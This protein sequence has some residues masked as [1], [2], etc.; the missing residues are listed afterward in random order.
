MIVL[1][2]LNRL[3]FTASDANDSH[4][5]RRIDRHISLRHSAWN[6]RLFIFFPLLLLCFSVCQYDG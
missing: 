3:N 5:S 1:A 6:L 2:V 4:Q